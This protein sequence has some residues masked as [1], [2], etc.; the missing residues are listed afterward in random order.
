MDW[1]YKSI[2]GIIAISQEL[3]EIQQKLE[4]GIEITDDEQKKL[5]AFETIKK[6]DYEEQKLECLL[7]LAIDE[8]ERQIY[9]NRYDAN[10]TEMLGFDIVKDAGHI[11]INRKK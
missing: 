11:I 3:A 10:K 2:W 9:I 5:D 4:N 8:K 6:T 7:Y 1:K